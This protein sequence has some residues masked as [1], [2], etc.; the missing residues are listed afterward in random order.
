M[1]GKG[2]F[3]FP[4][5]WWEREERKGLSIPSE[6]IVNCSHT[7]TLIFLAEILNIRVLTVVRKDQ[8]GESGRGE[9]VRENEWQV[10]RDPGDAGRPVSSDGV[11]VDSLM[12]DLEIEPL[13]R[14]G[15]DQAENSYIP[16]SDWVSKVCELRRVK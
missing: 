4:L 8:F 14:E 3:P 16:G 7:L 9:H 15:L 5:G 1:E 12:V 13:E 6:S 11:N 10:G 2:I